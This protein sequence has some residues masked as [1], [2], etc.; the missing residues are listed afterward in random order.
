MDAH[1]DRTDDR[2]T[3]CEISV[4]GVAKSVTMWA[5]FGVTVATILVQIAF[6]LLG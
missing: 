4:A 2:V 1:Q 3:Q 6:R 5:S